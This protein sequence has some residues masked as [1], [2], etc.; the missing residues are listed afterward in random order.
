MSPYK[1]MYGGEDFGWPELIIECSIHAIWGTTYP[2]EY[3]MNVK[4]TK[5]LC[6]DLIVEVGNPLRICSSYIKSCK[7][8]KF[9]IL[10]KGHFFFR[11]DP[12]ETYA[13]KSLTN[14]LINTVYLLYLQ[15]FQGK[16]IFEGPI[17]MITHQ[18]LMI[19]LSQVIKYWHFV[20]LGQATKPKVSLFEKLGMRLNNKL[21]KCTC[22]IYTHYNET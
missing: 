4:L 3:K 5:W 11:D 2:N 1:E 21:T 12:C 19:W 22:T 13:P 9:L 14:L 18:I 10:K 7:N 16:Y 6:P 17:C 20:L 8:S 15:I